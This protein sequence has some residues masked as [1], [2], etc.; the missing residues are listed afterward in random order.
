[1]VTFHSI[2]MFLSLTKFGYWLVKLCDFKCHTTMVTMT[3]NNC[4]NVKFLQIQ[5]FRFMLKS[6]LLKD[7]AVT[8]NTQ[9][10]PSW[11]HSVIYFLALSFL[12]DCYWDVLG[13]SW[14]RSLHCVCWTWRYQDRGES[15]ICT[16]KVPLDVLLSTSVAWFWLEMHEKSDCQ[17]GSVRIA[18]VVVLLCFTDLAHFIS[19]VI[20]CTEWCS[21]RSSILKPNRHF[22]LLF[23][24]LSVT[25]KISFVLRFKELSWTRH[26]GRELCLRAAIYLSS[27][28]NLCSYMYA[29]MHAPSTYTR[30][31]TP[32]SSGD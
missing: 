18:A 28:W 5:L 26:K 13:T 6:R 2:Y 17:F 15:F 11:F 21:N 24:R 7:C 10:F 3:W 32:E 30:K 31:A 4:Q 20:A 27:P 22:M 12:T 14:S 1:M 8:K 25:R 9:I 19:F 23:E 16:A 29:T